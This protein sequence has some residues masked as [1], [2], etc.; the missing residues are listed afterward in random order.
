VA[1][2][3]AESLH[4]ELKAPVSRLATDDIVLPANTILERAL[5]PDATAIAHRVRDIMEGNGPL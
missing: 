3:V 5:I 2:V 1:A 4:A